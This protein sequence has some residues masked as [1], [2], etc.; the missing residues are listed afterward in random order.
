MPPPLINDPQ[1]H[2]QSVCQQYSFFCPS[3]RVMKSCNKSGIKSLRLNRMV[4]KMIFNVFK[5]PD[6]TY[7]DWSSRSFA[8]RLIN[9]RIFVTGLIFVQPAAVYLYRN[10]LDKAF[11][12]N[13]LR[14]FLIPLTINVSFD[15]IN[16][17]VVVLIHC[18]CEFSKAETFPFIRGIRVENFRI[19]LLVKQV[20]SWPPLFLTPLVKL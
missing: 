12:C 5:L 18:N 3:P 1:D 8:I 10:V 16:S 15:A 9:N 6:F 19:F 13:Y 14:N 11:I 17:I 2:H 20:I 7:K 4:G